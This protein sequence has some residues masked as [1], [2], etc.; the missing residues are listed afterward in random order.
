MYERSDYVM[1]LVSSAAR[2]GSLYGE[3]NRRQQLALERIEFAVGELAS[4][5]LANCRSTETA[6]LAVRD[7]RKAIAP[8]LAAILDAD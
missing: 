7:V 1:N 3:P 8:V 5:L 6:A 2:G 4:V